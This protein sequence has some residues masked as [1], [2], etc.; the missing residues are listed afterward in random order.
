MRARPNTLL[1]LSAVLV[2]GAAGAARA[3]AT[4][5]SPQAAAS[6]P[7]VAVPIPGGST[8]RTQEA[9]VSD[10]TPGSVTGRGTITHLV[11]PG[12]PAPNANQSIRDLS[13]P[14]FQVAGFGGYVTAPVTAA[15]DQHNNL[16]TFAGQPGRGNTAVLA[17]SMYGNP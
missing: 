2:V 1:A 10:M 15:Y 13:A 5:D 6:A 8:V 3:Q 17:Q 14:V 7:G 12:I 11:R 16:A 9:S 4:L